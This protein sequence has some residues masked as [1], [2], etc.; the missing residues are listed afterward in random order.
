MTGVAGGTISGPELVAAA[1]SLYQEPWYETQFVEDRN[2][3]IALVGHGDRDRAVNEVWV[4]E[5]C[6]GVVHGVISDSAGRSKDP[7]DIFP[8]LSK[9]PFEVLPGLEGPFVVACIDTTDDRII[10]ATDKAG[11]RPIYFTDDGPFVFSSEVK[12]LLPFHANP[13]VDVAAVA[14]L[15]QIGFVVGERT[16]VDEIRNLPPAS[17]LTYSDGDVDIRKYWRPLFD[18]HPTDDFPNRW[19]EAFSNSLEDVSDTVDQQLS[20]WLSGGIDSRVTAAVLKEIGRSFDTLTYWNANG[21]NP[22]IAADVADELGVDNSLL[23]PGT[24]DQFVDGV[25]RGVAVT[26]GMMSWAPL[27]N[28]S[29]TF[30][31]LHDV[32]DVVMEGG[33]FM[34]EDVWDHSLYNDEPPA[35]ILLSKKQKLSSGVL[36]NL[37]SE[38]VDPLDSIRSEI[39]RCGLSGRREQMLY[40]MRQ[41]YA[42]SHMRSNIVQ[43]SQ[44][45]T[46]VISHGSVLEGALEIPDNYRMKTVPFTNGRIPAGVPKL[47]LEVMCRLGTEV[48]SIPYERTSMPPS[49]AY[50]LH[51][52]GFG[53]NQVRDI[54]RRNKSGQYLYWYRNDP[55]VREFLDDVLMDVADRRFL[56]HDAVVD[57]YEPVR[58]G[59]ND[60]LAPI[61]S[62]SALEIW[63][64]EYLD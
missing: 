62:L 45:G 3:G 10:L 4:G 64:R 14:D 20:L 9:D 52:V 27:V 63:L 13:S 32:A 7:E 41:L 36:N 33:T 38:P 24:P 47:K 43:R 18:Q 48:A 57:L 46:R 30:N 53:V 35:E 60:N 49:A 17:V 31:D 50:P 12:S 58:D 39:T 16:L 23:E 21:R 59:G 54:V 55:T 6:I 51:I 44:V 11:S 8:A 42:Y 19:L 28:L 2:T 34:G 37:V 61:A 40:G 1:E 25:R 5:H 26:D 29:F 22:G 56:N 15:I